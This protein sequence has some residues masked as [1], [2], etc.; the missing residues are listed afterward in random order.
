M[1]L[2]ELRLRAAR[3]ESKPFEGWKKLGIGCG[4]QEMSQSLWKN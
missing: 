1:G 3:D 2:Q 4:P